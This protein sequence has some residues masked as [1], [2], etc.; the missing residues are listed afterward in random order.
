MQQGICSALLIAT[1]Q[2]QACF[3]L[4]SEHLYCLG[5]MESAEKEPHLLRARLEELLRKQ[6]AVVGTDSVALA[7]GCFLWLEA[8]SRPAEILSLGLAC[9]SLLEEFLKVCIAKKQQFCL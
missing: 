3:A 8:H 7:T 2:Y 4:C 9:P 5:V 6:G 1:G